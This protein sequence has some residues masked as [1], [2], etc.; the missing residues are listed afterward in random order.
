MAE[1][2]RKR[3]IMIAAFVILGITVAWL[4]YRL[5]VS[6]LESA[7]AEEQVRI[8]YT[9]RDQARSSSPREAVDDLEYVLNYYPSGTKQTRESRL[10]RLVESVRTNVCSE[11]MA[12]LKGRTGQQINTPAGWIE[13]KSQTGQ[14]AQ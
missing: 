1:G 14:I 4:L 11:I 12:D 5:G 10:D 6:I 7:F 13:W 9:M 3:I 8:F 2:R